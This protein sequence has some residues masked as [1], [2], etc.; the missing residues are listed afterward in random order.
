VTVLEEVHSLKFMLV[1][2]TKAVIG[3]MDQSR[4]DVDRHQVDFVGTLHE[5]HVLKY[6]HFFNLAVTFEISNQSHFASL[7]QTLHDNTFTLSVKSDVNIA[8]M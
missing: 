8:A 5:K 2:V 1:T 3:L 4:I 7:E 6:T